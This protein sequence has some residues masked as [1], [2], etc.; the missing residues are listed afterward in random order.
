MFI[1]PSIHPSVLILSSLQKCFTPGKA[2]PP[3]AAPAKGPA[4][5]DS[6]GATPLPKAAAKVTTPAAAAL[7]KASAHSLL[8]SREDDGKL[9]CPTIISLPLKLISITV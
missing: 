8:D 7:K 3:A 1:H 2:I 6:K 9:T 4:P 5:G